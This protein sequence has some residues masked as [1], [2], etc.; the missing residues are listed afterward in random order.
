[1]ASPHTYMQVK[2]L[3]GA[4]PATC[5]LMYNFRL[6]EQEKKV[7]LGNADYKLKKITIV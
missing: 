7:C 5:L 2:V 4:N 6:N 3:V 1:M